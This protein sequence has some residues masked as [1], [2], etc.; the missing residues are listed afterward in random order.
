M[1]VKD[2]KIYCLLDYE[3]F[4]LNGSLEKLLQNKIIKIGDK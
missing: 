4:Y 1:H 2:N 3:D